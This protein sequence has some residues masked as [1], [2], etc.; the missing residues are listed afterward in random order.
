MD[1]SVKKL[2]GVSDAREKALGNLGVFTLRD[3]LEF[4]PRAY[5]DRSNVV[6][7]EA[8][9]PDTEV[10]VRGR[11]LSVGPTRT[12]RR[13]LT[14]TQ[15][16]IQDK[17][18]SLCV[19]F[20]NQNYI[21]RA[22]VP[23]R[24]YCFFGKITRGY[25]ALELCNPVF[26]DLF[27]EGGD[28]ERPQPVY[29]LTKGLSQNVLRRLMKTLLGETAVFPETLPQPV[30]QKFNLLSFDSAVRT[31]HFPST[32]SAV[33]AARR[34]LVFE[35]FVTLVLML[36]HIKQDCAEAQR[37][38]PFQS[39]PRAERFLQSLPFA[40][41]E[42]QEKVW[43]EIRADMESPKVMNRLVMGDV[44]SGK[45]VIA[46]LAMLE[47]VDSGYQA[48]FMVPTEILAEQHFVTMQRFFA[49]LGI[50]CAMLTGSL[51]A[52]EKRRVTEGLADGSVSCVVGTHALIQKHVKIQ[53]PGIVI[54]DEQHR[55]GVRQR[56]ALSAAGE[57]CD[58]LVMTATPIPR[59]LALI[60]YGDL[61]ISTIDRLPAGRLPIRTYA[62][63]ESY[64]ERVYTW[65]RRLAEAGQQ[66]YIVHPLIEEN[67]E[68][69]LASAEEN[70]RRATARYF[71]G[72]ST[73]LVH[74]KMR[75]AER[76]A[77]M[78]GFVNGEISVL[79]STT[80][81]EVGVDV[82]NATLMI[83]ENAERFGLA[84]LHQLRGR[85][86]RGRLQSHC[87]LFAHGKGETVKE[88]M[89]IM[90][91]SSDGFRIAEKD[92]ELRGPGE[93]FGTVQHGIPKFK[94]ANLYEDTAVLQEAIAAA[95]WIAGSD[96]AEL[97]NYRQK[98]LAKIPEKLNL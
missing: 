76:D 10:T 62:V 78:R 13:N 2:K 65:A 80:V 46:L 94:L 86:G 68:S 51:S 42:S 50:S 34:R 92:L 4:Y 88:R 45:T 26:A 57:N 75:A 20:Y 11:V 89:N 66:V 28:F 30:L 61:D 37:G 97:R 38:I 27:R 87:V 81:I 29:P 63:D 21:K 60:L 15:V 33:P 73:A 12:V 16:L 41:S 31:V 56:Q 18:A 59:T 39:S 90:T 5:E 52:A 6:P 36:R 58:I 40:L 95:E 14:V 69:D 19:V 49:P 98:I 91:A 9:V 24:D 43:R 72:I 93:L 96:D 79:F 70:F 82:P 83:I 74:G 55:F 53:N 1:D 32:M 64:R 85:V 71:N 3:F 7:I 54:T 25:R 77:V 8:L 17:T 23:G 48:V 84:Q 35:E 67:A 22:L 44:G 47:A